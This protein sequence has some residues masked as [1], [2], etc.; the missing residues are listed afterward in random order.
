MAG[1]IKECGGMASFL[2]LVMPYVGD[3]S[4]LHLTEFANT[5]DFHLPTLVCINKCGKYPESEDFQSV[6]SVL[7]ARQRYASQLDI[8]SAN[9]FFTDFHNCSDSMRSRGVFG[10]PTVRKWIRNKLLE[11]EFYKEDEEEL[12]HAINVSLS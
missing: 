9:V 12:D 1:V 8:N 2:I 3:V 6:V 10:I 4:R 5:E 7:K 11:Y